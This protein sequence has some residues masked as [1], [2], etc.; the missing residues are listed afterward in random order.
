[1]A[2]LRSSSSTLGALNAVTEVMDIQDADD[3]AL[4]IT[5]TF[6]GTITFYISVDDVTY[7]AFAMHQSSNTAGTTDI[8]TATTAAAV[9]KDCAPYQYFKAIM[10]AYTSGSATAK[11]FT[12]RVAK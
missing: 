5:G 9:S 12:S 2:F 6:V 10:T 8:S 7:Y 3:V 11:I 1:M 4:A